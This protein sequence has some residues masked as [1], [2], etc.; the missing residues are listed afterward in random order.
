[1]LTPMCAEQITKLTQEE[2]QAMNQS[3]LLETIWKGEELYR[4]ATCERDFDHRRGLERSELE[5]VLFLVQNMLQRKKP[6]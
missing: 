4:G 2:V 6:R 5:R 3:Q 1:M